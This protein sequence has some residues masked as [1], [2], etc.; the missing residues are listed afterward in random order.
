M[1]EELKPCPICDDPMEYV[2]G[3][4]YFRH[5]DGSECILGDFGWA[6]DKIAAWN[7]R[8]KPVVKALHWEQEP[9]MPHLWDADGMGI[10][11][12]V[13]ELHDGTASLRIGNMNRE[14]SAHENVEAA[15]SF[16]NNHNTRRVHAC[17]EGYDD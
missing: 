14:H 17:L 7:Q 13:I 9:D 5:V 12:R 11:Y 6:R 8:A 15:F 10:L 4:D 1:I 2:M 3:G 16:A